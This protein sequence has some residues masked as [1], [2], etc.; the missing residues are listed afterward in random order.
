MNRTL[1]ILVSLLLPLASACSNRQMYDAVK[2]RQK[3]LCES[4]PRSSYGE[5][6][7]QADESYDTYARDR[8]ALEQG[9]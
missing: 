9:R 2:N 7:E 3:V 1:C 8:E 5:C 6:L 4:E